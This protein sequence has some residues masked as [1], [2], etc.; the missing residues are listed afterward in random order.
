MLDMQA[1]KDCPVHV[2][3][4]DDSSRLDL[5][6]PGLTVSGLARAEIEIMQGDGVYFCS[7]Q[8]TCAAEIDCSRCL[9]PYPMELCGE[10]EF[11]IHEMADA[12]TVRRDEIPETEIIVPPHAAQV[13]ITAPVR[14][15][16]MLEIPLKPLC[17]EECRGLCPV[18]GANRNVERCSCVVRETDTRWDGLRGL[19]GDKRA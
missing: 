2:S 17:R 19:F 3:L 9:E 16:L 11:S 8:V 15:A 4:S 1:L 10:I 14:E 13:D 5:S 7:G 12:D 6:V 18:C